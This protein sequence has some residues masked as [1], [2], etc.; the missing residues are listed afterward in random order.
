MEKKTPDEKTKDDLRHHVL[1]VSLDPTHCWARWD[2]RRNPGR[3]ARAIRCFSRWSVYTAN[4]VY[5]IPANTLARI[6]PHRKSLAILGNRPSAKHWTR[7]A[8]A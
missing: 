8:M 3:S 4:L 2:L 1:L 5:R 7:V 6:R